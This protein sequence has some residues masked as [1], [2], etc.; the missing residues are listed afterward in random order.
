MDFRGELELGNKAESHQMVF[1]SMR[2]IEVWEMEETNRKVTVFELERKPSKSREEIV[3]KRREWCIISNAASRS[4]KMRID[5]C[6]W[7]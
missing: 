2:Q 5:N 7:I 1:R 3:L 6:H 4:N